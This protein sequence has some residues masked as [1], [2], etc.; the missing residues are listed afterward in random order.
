[1]LEIGSLVDG[2]YRILSKVGQ[3]GMSVVYMARNDRANKMWA[4]KEIR[5][6]GTQN[7][8]VVKQ[9]LIV[10]TDMLKRLDH[11]HL[12]SIIDVIDGEGSFLIVMDFIEG[13][14][15][16]SMLDEYGP[17]PQE[18]V[19]DWARQ[20]CDVLGYLHSRKPP[21]IY[22]DMKP[23]NV[24]LKPDG[25]VV[26]FDF[27]T[28]REYK[29]TS[30]EDTTLLGTR[31][32]A[33]PEQYGGHGQTDAR[34]DIYCLGATMYH[35]LTGHNPSQPP[36]TMYPIR[37]WNPNLSKG[38]EA[39]VLKCT[40]SNPIDR[41][42]SCAELMYALDHYWENDKEYRKQQK[43]KMTLFMIPAIASVLFGAG[44]VTFNVMASQA[45][46]SNYDAFLQAA[47]TS[48]DYQEEI[49]YYRKA[50]DLN[51]SK[52]E[53]YQKL[54]RDCLL[55]DDVLTAEED[56]DL[57]AILNGYGS[58]KES[59]ERVFA[60]K[61][62]AEYDQFM[63]EVGIAYYYNSQNSGD[64]KYAKNCFDTAQHS[65]Y[66][67]S[68][69]VE[70]AKRLYKI[71]DYYSRIGIIDKT[72]DATVTYRDY[73]NDLV[74]LTSGNLVAMDN[75]KTALIMYKEN[76][77]QIVTRANEFKRDGVTRNEMVEQLD[78][79]EMRLQS[80]FNDV[81]SGNREAIDAEIQTLRTNMQQA[82]NVIESTFSTNR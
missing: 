8:D 35:L 30:M 25:N 39:I 60:N 51:P 48:T 80:D 31:G 79:I 15:L 63:Y 42:Q 82:R 77:A 74:E 40:Q 75:A 3:G 11:P 58:G 68:K 44:A 4:I 7:F 13:K 49:G 1:M 46:T 70:R 36:Y 23:S 56:D 55:A 53:A 27:G 81:G 24:M 45:K 18:N 14:T 2:K 52:S 26:L 54:L 6:D 33:A 17:Q 76:V 10:E 41:Y 47:S 16:K 72:G 59:N 67:T 22:R 69:Q 38:L 65:A 57:R 29:I 71:C 28:A 12:P 21:I 43:K 62:K 20:L 19:I 66:L 9:G 64:K 37:E 50:I 61:N 34:T 78:Y 5:K 73:W 32:Y